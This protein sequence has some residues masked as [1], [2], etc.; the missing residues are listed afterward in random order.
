MCRLP[1][2]PLLLSSI[3]VLGVL[4]PSRLA[5]QPAS[6]VAHERYL[7]EAL[8]ID[9]TFRADTAALRLAYERFSRLLDQPDYAADAHY[10]LAFADWQRSQIGADDQEEAV[11]L[12]DRANEHL[13]ATIAATP[14]ALEAYTLQ[15]RIDY[16]LGQ[17][18]PERQQ[19]VLARSRS[20]FDSLRALDDGHPLYFQNL[21][22]FTFFTPPEYGG[23]PIEGVELFQRSLDAFAARSGGTP[24]EQFW[25]GWTYMAFAQAL[26]TRGEV[27]QAREVLERALALRPD[28]VMVREGMLP[29]THPVAPQPKRD[30]TH[31]AWQLLAEDTAGDGRMPD[32]PDG[33]HL[34]AAY[35][36]ATDTLWF[37]V[38]LHNAL[39]PEAIGLNLAFDID[40]DQATGANWWGQNRAFRYDRLVTL[41]ITQQAPGEVYGALGL[42]DHWGVQQGR[43]LNLGQHNLAYQLDPARQEIVVGIRRSDLGTDGPLHVIATVGS[44]TTWNDDLVDT[45]FAVLE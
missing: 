39:S 29:L 10:F 3:I 5:A 25:H 26:L 40:H 19:E 30:L 21:A 23:D 4:I 1:N 14:D 17:L 20:A 2:R 41:W 34:Y 37:K 27:A 38:T 33:E 35:D 8:L 18:A 22:L 11:A 16:W 31:L 6:A 44:N 24:Q 12:L 36:T 28:F 9:A 15:T 42:G 32:L 43:F 45:G 13:Q 7:A